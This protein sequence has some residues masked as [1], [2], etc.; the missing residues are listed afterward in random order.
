[1][2]IN[3]SRRQV[4]AGRGAGGWRGRVSAPGGFWEGGSP[5]SRVLRAGWYLGDGSGSCPKRGNSQNQYNLS[6]RQM[7]TDRGRRSGAP[8]ELPV[9]P[10]PSCSPAPAVAPPCL[11]FPGKRICGRCGFDH[12]VP[13]HDLLPSHGFCSLGLWT[14]CTNCQQLSLLISRGLPALS[15]YRHAG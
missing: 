1:M 11:G 9:S 5:G 4:P 12:V 13:R 10:V 8:R 2:P 15:V 7:P 3:I 14:P 6:F